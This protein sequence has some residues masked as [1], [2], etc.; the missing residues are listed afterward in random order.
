MDIIT[1]DDLKKEEE[2]DEA[3]EEE[4]E[5]EEDYMDEINA[6]LE[7]TKKTG[8]GKST[9]EGEEEEGRFRERLPAARAQG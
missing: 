6:F 8:D 9:S 1:N 7:T 4:A 2:E 3:E 5:D